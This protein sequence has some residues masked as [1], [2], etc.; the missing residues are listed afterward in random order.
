MP[1]LIAVLALA[2]TF[3]LFVSGCEGNSERAPSPPTDV[4]LENLLQTQLSDEFTPDREVVVSRVEIPPDTM[5]ERH[6]HPGEEFIYFLEGKGYL[7]INGDTTVGT[8]G[9]IIHVPYETMH[10]GVTGEEGAKAVVF[11]VHTEGE[12]VRHLEKDTTA[13]G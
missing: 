6:W 9:D 10:T 5:L 3:G 4:K 8:P 7:V 13:E 2:L 1:R 12:P 11:R